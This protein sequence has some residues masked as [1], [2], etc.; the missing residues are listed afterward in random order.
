MPRRYIFCLQKKHAG[1]AAICLLPTNSRAKESGNW[2]EPAQ[3]DIYI[4]MI[5]AAAR[6]RRACC[7]WREKTGGRQD[8]FPQINILVY[9]ATMST[10]FFVALII[11]VL[12]I[13]HVLG[14]DESMILRLF[15]RHTKGS[16]A[17]S[18]TCCCHARHLDT[19]TP[20]RPPSKP[21]YK[22][23]AYRHATTLHTQNELLYWYPARL[24]NLTFAPCLGMFVRS[25]K[26]WSVGS[27]HSKS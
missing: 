21:S 2:R 20:M 22:H 26:M 5:A 11:V 14:S 7:H 25:W 12:T 19:S 15:S 27:S 8:C 17:N 6:R 10:L 3:K 24:L 9:S 13:W 16:T 4:Y 23:Y 1:K 18:R